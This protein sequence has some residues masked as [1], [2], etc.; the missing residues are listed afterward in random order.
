MYPS[1]TIYQTPHV[2]YP[3]NNKQQ[4]QKKKKKNYKELSQKMDTLLA[5]CFLLGNTKV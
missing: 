2:S 3:N 4:C 5:L 1:Q